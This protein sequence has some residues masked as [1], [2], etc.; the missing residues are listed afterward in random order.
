MLSL[1]AEGRPHP[2]LHWGLSA[3]RAGARKWHSRSLA[4]LLD[5]STNQSMFRCRASPISARIS[6]GGG[7]RAGP[8]HGGRLAGRPPRRL[9]FV[10]RDPPHHARRPQA[11]RS[12]PQSAPSLAPVARLGFG[13]GP[14][15]LCSLFAIPSPSVSSSSSFLPHPAF[16]RCSLSPLSPLAPTAGCRARVWP[17]PGPGGVACP[18]DSS[19]VL[20]QARTGPGTR[21]SPSPHRN[22]P[23]P[24]W[25]CAVAWWCCRMP[26]PVCLHAYVRECLPLLGWC[27]VLPPDLPDLPLL[28][29]PASPRY[30][31]A[32]GRCTAQ[33]LRARAAEQA[34][35][36]SPAA[37]RARRAG[38]GVGDTGGIVILVR[39]AA[40]PVEGPCRRGQPRRHAAVNGVLGG[41]S[42]LGHLPSPC[43][44]SGLRGRE[45]RQ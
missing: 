14:A 37:T 10:C 35:G 22:M 38:D 7:N 8:N 42:F 24:G 44:R 17:C 13:Q 32:C 31:P 29:L 1:A 23:P 9:C 34:R 21:E 25:L 18:A 4:R 15:F 2:P 11:H 5:Q 3:P 36:S 28:P 16:R 20:T 30:R 39:A 45:S 12:A 40:Q 26:G 6:I 27:A 41:V 43:G 19:G 33:S